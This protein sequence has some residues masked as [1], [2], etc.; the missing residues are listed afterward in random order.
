MIRSGISDDASTN[1]SASTNRPSASEKEACFM[2]R[3]KAGAGGLEWVGGRTIV[4]I[5]R[6]YATTYVC[7]SSSSIIGHSV[8][9]NRTDHPCTVL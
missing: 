7:H 4:M 8:A 9:P 6:F 2:N 5:L 1:A 3:A